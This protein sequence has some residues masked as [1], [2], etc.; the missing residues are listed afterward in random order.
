VIS[1]LETTATVTVPESLLL[2]AA[3]LPLLEQAPTA[4]SAATQPTAARVRTL[5]GDDLMNKPPRR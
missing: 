5:N 1:G 4:S 2:L 3:V